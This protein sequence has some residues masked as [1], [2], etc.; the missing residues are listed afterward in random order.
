MRE[1]IK[2]LISKAKFIISELEKYV[3]EEK[4]ISPVHVDRIVN[5]LKNE[6]QAL[7]AKSLAEKLANKYKDDLELKIKRTRESKDTIINQLAAE[8]GAKF[9]SDNRIKE[10]VGRMIH[11]KKWIYYYKK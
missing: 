3:E 6:D 4:Y 1:E 11:D 9:S 2:D 5:L 7:T 8:I 10:S